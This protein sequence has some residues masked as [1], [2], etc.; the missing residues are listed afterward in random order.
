MKTGTSLQ[1]LA[2]LYGIRSHVTS[3]FV[4]S[5]QLVRGYEKNSTRNGGS[6]VADTESAEIRLLRSELTPSEIRYY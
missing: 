3:H 1:D 2:I 6:R 4:L 5:S